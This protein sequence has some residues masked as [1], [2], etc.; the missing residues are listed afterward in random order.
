MTE[1]GIVLVVDDEDATRLYVSRHLQQYYTVVTA[2]NGLEA[3]DLLQTHVVTLVL[4]DLIMPGMSGYQLLERLKA[5]PKL[6]SIPVII[7]SIADDL[8]EVTRCLQLG[9]VDY[10]FKPV[11]SILLK[12]RVDACL[13]RST[14]P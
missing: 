3:L 9:A 7:I 5:D 1:H 6:C 12:A 2:V 14:L 10:L 4:L 13:K 11:N 8:E